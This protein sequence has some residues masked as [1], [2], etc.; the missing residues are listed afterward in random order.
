[1]EVEFFADDPRKKARDRMQDIMGKGTDQLAVASAFCTAAGVALLQKQVPRLRNPD[2]FVVVS[3]AYPTDY[4]ALAKLYASIPDNL[5]THWGALAPY[6]KK[7]GAALM[8]SKVIY[9]R[10]GDECWLW[11]G[12]HNLTA[13]ATQG[14]NCEAAVILH[15]A[16][17]EQPF[18]DALQHLITCR[19]EA[20]LYDPDAPPPGDDAQRENILVIHAEGDPGTTAPLPWR[21]HLCLNSAE[22]DGMLS[23]PA[24]V[25]LFLYPSGTLQSGWR[26]STPSA[27]FS[28]KLTGLN[29]TARNPNAGRAGTT[30]EW[31]AAHFNI[32]ES[33]NVLVLAPPGPPGADVTTQCVLFMDAPSSTL[34]VLFSDKPRVE[35]QPIEGD[36]GFSIV[37]SD[38]QKYFRKDHVRGMALIHI[39]VVGR[40]QVIRVAGDE[41]RERDFGRIRAAVADNRDFPVEYEAMSQ[42]R[43]IKRHPFIVRAKYRLRDTE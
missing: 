27:A 31:S 28:G 5:Y 39:P 33:S 42:E 4:P 1:M 43:L 21:I 20:T 26:N 8:H 17:N 2:S 9:A 3:V 25:R 11:T 23:A 15:G 34:E 32:V 36:R 12:S 7:A 38:M 37:D 24:Q 18:V 10:S 41:A 30:A 29:L 35:S 22:F 14:G 16:A 40:R 6:E 19:T 13:N